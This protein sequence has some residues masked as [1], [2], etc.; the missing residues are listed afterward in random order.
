MALDAVSVTDTMVGDVTCPSGPLEP[1]GS[2]VC[3]GSYTI[4]QD[5][6]DAGSVTNIAQGH[7]TYGEG[8]EVASDEVSLTIT[9]LAPEPAGPDARDGSRRDDLQRGRRG[10]RLRRT[11]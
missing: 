8:E 7:G 5:D 9:Y 2:V 4:T 6:L 3:V 10:H 11:G 1:G